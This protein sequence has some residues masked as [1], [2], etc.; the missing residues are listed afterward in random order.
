M[1]LPGLRRDEHDGQSEGAADAFND[2]AASSET[3]RADGPIGRPR[4]D[5]FAIDDRGRR[6]AN[7]VREQRRVQRHPPFRAVGQRRHVLDAQQLA[8]FR[9]DRDGAVDAGIDAENNTRGSL[10]RFPLPL[11]GT[12]VLGEGVYDLVFFRLCDNPRER[13][14]LAVSAGSLLA[15]PACL[16]GGADGRTPCL[17]SPMAS[18]IPS[19]SHGSAIAGMAVSPCRTACAASMAPT[20][21]TRSGPRTFERPASAAGISSTSRKRRSRRPNAAQ[22]FCPGV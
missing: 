15:V 17:R 10:T 16:P 20:S 6:P 12:I 13:Q 21:A 19:V 3:E 9:Q 11:N 22:A 2:A 1:P 14:N 8:G 4:V 5:E 7:D 18:R